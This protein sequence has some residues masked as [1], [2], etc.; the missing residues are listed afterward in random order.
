MAQGFMQ[1][2]FVFR[3]PQA[4]WTSSVATALWATFSHLKRGHLLANGIGML[5]MLPAAIEVS[6]TK[7]C[8]LPAQCSLQHLGRIAGARQFTW[9]IV[10]TQS[11]F[12]EHVHR[13]DLSLRCF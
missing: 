3:V 11:S 6:L 7:L 1:R 12:Q 2:H 4:S 13:T 5:G 8:Q 9:S 10:R